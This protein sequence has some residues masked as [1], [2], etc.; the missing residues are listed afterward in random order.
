MNN[1]RN[2]QSEKTTKLEQLRK[3][4]FPVE[5]P[6]CIPDF[7]ICPLSKNL[8]LDPV[9][10]PPGNSYERDALMAHVTS[11]GCYDPI[12]NQSF[13]RNLI[14]PNTTLKRVIEEF[15]EKNPW[16]YEFSINENYRDIQF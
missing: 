14:I 16:A 1:T 15:L 3:I 11:N 9:I 8:M 5:Q 12:S 13:E 4:L 6:K 2:S 7:M 10:V